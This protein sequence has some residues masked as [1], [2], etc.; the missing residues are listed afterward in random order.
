MLNIYKTFSEFSI[1]VSTKTTFYRTS[2]RWVEKCLHYFVANLFRI[3]HTKFYQ[4]R[5]SFAE[6]M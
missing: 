3:L 2:F 5:P 1:G 4:N 6:D